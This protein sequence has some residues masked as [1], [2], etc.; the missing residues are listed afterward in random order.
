MRTVF[1]LTAASLALAACNSNSD[2][3]AGEATMAA[4]NVDAGVT[5]PNMAPA[6]GAVAA[7]NQQFVDTVAASDLFEIQSSELAQNK[8]TS[9]AVKDFAAMMIDHHTK[10]SADL[11][12]AALA[13]SPS[14]PVAP[15]L[16]AAQQADL[17]ALR[18]ATGDFDKQ[19]V[20]KQVAAH[21]AARSLLSDYSA[22]GAP[23]PLRDFASKTVTVVT[24]HLERARKL[25]Q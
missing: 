25:P 3:P 18:G 11:K 22:V 21:E 12:Q 16:T 4:D 5:S 7:G 23:G 17:D 1:L 19:Y 9:K 10:S 2:T 13:A 20:Q 14:L 24:G 6:A 8:A 15:R